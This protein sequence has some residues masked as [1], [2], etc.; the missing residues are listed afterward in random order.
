[1]P[2]TAAP[3]DNMAASHCSNGG[4]LALSGTVLHAHGPDAQTQNDMAKLLDM[5]P[6]CTHSDA[7]QNVLVVVPGASTVYWVPDT[8]PPLR[9]PLGTF[10]PSRAA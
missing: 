9:A 4:I 8:A 5:A 6:L 10:S 3:S 1:M 2:S 7:A